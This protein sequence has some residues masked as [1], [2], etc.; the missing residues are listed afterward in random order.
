MYPTLKRLSNQFL[1]HVD[2]FCPLLLIQI[3]VLYYAILFFPMAIVDIGPQEFKG[4]K[5]VSVRAHQPA[6]TFH[7][8]MPLL[9]K[10]L[11]RALTVNGP[12]TPN[13][14]FMSTRFGCVV[15]N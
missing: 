6:A 15:R 11:T 9:L 1:A 4:R 13:L 5:H 14:Y 10:E 2:S 3:I 7:R 12:S 8:L